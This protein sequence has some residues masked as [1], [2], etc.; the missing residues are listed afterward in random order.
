MKVA[1]FTIKLSP[2]DETLFGCF[3]MHQAP[4]Y[5]FFSTLPALPSRKQPTHSFPFAKSAPQKSLS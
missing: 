2:P 3:A 1:S 4:S 5:G